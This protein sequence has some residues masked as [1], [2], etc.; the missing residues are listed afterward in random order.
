MRGVIA[1]TL[2]IPPLLYSGGAALWGLFVVAMQ[3]DEICDPNSADWR[4]TRGAWHWYA[5]AALGAATIVAGVLFFHSI[6]GRG[7]RAALMWLLLGTAT[8]AIGLWR[9]R[10][11][12]GSDRDLDLEPSF[13]A[14]SA[15]VFVSGVVAALLALP[16]RARTG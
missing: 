15:A 4:Y 7:P 1:I 5:I 2:A 3:C 6:V 10:V 14:V 8:V 9:L 13:F 11:N 12:P 16:T